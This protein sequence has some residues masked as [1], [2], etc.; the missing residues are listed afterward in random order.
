M[1][2]H[3]T[4]FFGLALCIIILSAAACTNNSSNPPVCI[5]ANTSGSNVYDI[6]WVSTH[7]NN[8]AQNFP[9]SGYALQGVYQQE[10]FQ[11]P[12]I[13]TFYY[14]DETVPGGAG[15]HEMLFEWYDCDGN[16]LCSDDGDHAINGCTTFPVPIF[17]TPL[18]FWAY[19]P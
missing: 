14:L 10:N 17:T 12:I 8:T 19:T 13:Y 7:A 3:F 1:K 4:T 6:S 15:K 5:D 18:N 2:K 11:T 9:N 16:L